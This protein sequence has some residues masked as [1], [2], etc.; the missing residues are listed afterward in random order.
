MP[1]AIKKRVSRH[2]GRKDRETKNIVARIGATAA[3]GGKRLA[4]AAL[5]AAVLVI[6]AFGY[7]IYQRGLTAKA[8]GYEYEGYKLY[9]GLYQ[10][11]PMVKAE[12]LKAALESF[13]KA[14]MLR[15]TPYALFYFADCQYALGSYE[16]AISLLRELI[17]KFPDNTEF[18]PLAYYKMAMA[19][20]KKG[21]TEGAMRFLDDLYGYPTDSFKD[22]ALLEQARILERM[23]KTQEAY[24]K[25]ATIV[26]DFP[27][28]PFFDEASQRVKGGKG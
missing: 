13:Q 18:V 5:I 20:I 6:A 24:E 7:Y 10:G 14:Y 21:D 12:R 2:A 4:A 9:Y 16:E 17:Q 27:Q 28:S 22:L 15:K 19:S 23:G 8:R 1:K 26:R 3:R 25:Y 11:R